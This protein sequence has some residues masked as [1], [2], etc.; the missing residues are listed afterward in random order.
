MI[1]ALHGCH[2]SMCMWDSSQHSVV[3]VK[4]LEVYH[5]VPFL[6]III[7]IIVIIIINIIIITILLS[8][9]VYLLALCFTLF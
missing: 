7:I 4:Y 8:L 3:I 2:V 6:F 9:F 5:S 1:Q